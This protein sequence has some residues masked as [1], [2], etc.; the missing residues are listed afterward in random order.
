MK[1]YLN[2]QEVQELFLKLIR[3]KDLVKEYETS[4]LRFMLKEIEWAKEKLDENP[5]D[6]FPS[7]NILTGGKFSSADF[8]NLEDGIDLHKE[9]LKLR[10]VNS[11]R[12]MEIVSTCIMEEVEIRETEEY[13]VVIPSSKELADLAYKYKL[14]ENMG[15]IDVVK[16][17]YEM[18][19]KKIPSKPQNTA[20][21]RHL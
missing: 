3:N 21:Y 4:I 8:I 17:V 19:G 18:I 13:D 5:R 15:K 7:I 16:L 6:V 2:S 12:N 11:Y 9:V 14:L 20:L 1:K 10:R